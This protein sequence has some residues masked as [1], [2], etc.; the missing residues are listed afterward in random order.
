M[1]EEHRPD[2]ICCRY[3]V[4]QLESSQASPLLLEEPR[5][6]YE[7]LAENGVVHGDPGLHNFCL[8]LVTGVVAIDF[9]LPCPLPTDIPNSD[10]LHTFKTEITMRAERTRGGEG[11]LAK[12][13]F[14][15]SRYRDG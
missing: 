14:G 3:T 8:R 9:E 4:F 2:L 11:R 5:A 12:P 7:L 15:Y 6:T 13:D 10:V 1:R